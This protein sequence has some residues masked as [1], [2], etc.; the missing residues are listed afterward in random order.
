MRLLVQT[1]NATTPCLTNRQDVGVAF[2]NLVKQHD[3]VGLFGKLLC[4]LATVLK[5]NVAWRTANQLGTFV[6]GLVLGH[7]KPDKCLW[8]L[9]VGVLCQAFG[10]LRL[11]ETRRAKKQKDQRPVFVMPAVFFPADGG[12][13]VVEGRFLPHNVLFETLFQRKQPSCPPRLERFAHL[14]LL[15]TRFKLLCIFL[16]GKQRVVVCGQVQ[17]RASFVVLDQGVCAMGLQQLQSVR[18][19]SNDCIVQSCKPCRV[20]HWVNRNLEGKVHGSSKEVGGPFLVVAVVILDVYVSAVFEEQLE[21]V[22]VTVDGCDVE[23]RPAQAM[24]FIGIGACP[25]RCF[26]HAVVTLQHHFA[27]V[28]TA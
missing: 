28:V 21:C 1:R 4:E 12:G 27:D 23:R 2:F 14:E 5:P 25:Q 3:S 11:A 22:G 16:E 15:L 26:Q 6:F 24:P 20:C 19:S 17:C 9:F 10:N 18:S 8:V 13:N 7:V